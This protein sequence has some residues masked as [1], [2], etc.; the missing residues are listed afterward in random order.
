M[1]A[2]PNL[3]F[4][5]FSV[6]AF[7]GVQAQSPGGATRVLVVGAVGGPSDVTM[8]MLTSQLGSA[9]GQQF[10]VENRPGTV[11]QSAIEQ[12]KNAAPDG[13]TLMLGNTGTHSIMPVFY[14][15]NRFDPSADTAPI[16]LIN[17]TGLVLVAHPSLP[18]RSMSNLLT[19]ARKQPGKLNIGSAGPT[20]EIAL[21]ALMKA[22]GFRAESIRYKGSS[23]AE[24][25]A[26]SG[27]VA[28]AL[29][30]PVACVSHLK[31]GRLYAIGVTTAS[32]LTLLP[33]VPTFSESGLAGYSFEFWNGL[34]A[35]PNTPGHLIQVLNREV[36]K[37]VLGGDTSGRY[38]SMGFHT[39]ASSPE[40][41]SETISGEIAKFR[42]LQTETGISW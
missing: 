17:S 8:R 14:K 13:R 3:M 27:E 18:V 7:S 5:V 23:P 31:S 32:R 30:T 2:L 19:L 38:S 22:A 33:D 24:V 35:P 37:V 6:F 29:L 4:C 28:M 16:S 39:V 1:K 26:I 36:V 15:S 41:L 20:G 12:V 42:K 11:A 40:K 9:L 25:A 21:S 10:V 34:F